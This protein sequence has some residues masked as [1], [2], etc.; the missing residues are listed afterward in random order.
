MI[1][2]VGGE[3]SLKPP[4]SAEDPV[5]QF[6]ILRSPGPVDDIVGSHDHP[7]IRLLDSYFEGFEVDLAQS[8]LGQAGVGFKAVGLLVVAGKVLGTGADLAGLDAADERCGHLAC[9]KGIFGVV[10]EVPAAERTAVDV[11][12]G[13]QPDRDVIFLHF[14]ASCTADLFDQ[15]L[16]PGAGQEGGAGKCC[17][18]D[19]DAGLDAE[20]GGPVR[21]HDRGDT[22]AGE[23]SH[24]EGIGGPGVGLPAEET[25]PVFQGKP[26]KKVLKIR[27]SV[28]HL[29][30]LNRIKRSVAEEIFAFPGPGPGGENTCLFQA[31]PDAGGRFVL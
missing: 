31:F 15:F 24:S 23:V 2:P 27:A 16:V 10:L 21:S 17:G 1:P 12:G 29:Q 13:R 18:G 26:G 9:K 3:H 30:K 28:R 14:H 6:F 11:H 5:D 25:D 22:I 7:G 20:T 19:T 8:P 4:F